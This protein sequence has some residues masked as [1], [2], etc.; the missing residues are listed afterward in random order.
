MTDDTSPDRYAS[1]EPRRPPV[2]RDARSRFRPVRRGH[3]LTE[4]YDRAPHRCGSRACRPRRSAGRSH[5]GASYRHPGRGAFER[6]FDGLAAVEDLDLEVGV[7]EIYGFLGPNGAGKTTTVRK[8]TPLAPTGGRA[9][10]AGHDVATEPEQVRCG[11]ARRYKRPHSTGKQT[12]HELLMLQGRLYGLSRRQVV[13]RVDELADLVDI[14]DAPRSA[15]RDLPGGMKR[16]L[17]VAAAP[18]HNPDVLFPD[19]P[20]T[21]LDPISRARVWDECGG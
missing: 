4:R 19:E 10:V 15:H 12:G 1:D 11:L 21:G 13:R 20:T 18:V 6:C 5:R 3:G 8:R 16:R 7:G 2:F 9:T 17:D 14:G